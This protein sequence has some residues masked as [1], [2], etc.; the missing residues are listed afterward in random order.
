MACKAA[1]VGSK[2]RR[3]VVIAGY[4]SALWV[5]VLRTALSSSRDQGRNHCQIVVDG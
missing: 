2:Y 4:G 3:A 1:F 5:F